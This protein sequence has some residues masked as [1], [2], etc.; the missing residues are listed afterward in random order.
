MDIKLEDL[1]REIH[2]ALSHYHKGIAD[3]NTLLGN[4]LLVQQQQQKLQ[5]QNVPTR[6]RLATNAVLLSGVENLEQQFPKEAEILR[7]RFFDVL[8]IEKA[9]KKVGYSPDHANRLQREGIKHLAEIL[10]AQEEMARNEALKSLTAYLPRDNDGVKLFGVDELRGRLL[11]VLLRPEQ[12]WIVAITGI[13]GIGKT[14]LAESLAFEVAKRF[15]FKHI[16]YHRVQD[17]HLGSDMANPAGVYDSFLFDMSRQLWPEI[18]D[19][20]ILANENKVLQGLKENPNLIII[21]NLELEGDIDYLLEKASY[22]VNPS[23]LLLTSRFQ[24]YQNRSI[25]SETVNALSEPDSLALM[26]HQAEVANIATVKQA[27]DE[28]LKSIFERTGGNPQALKL[29][30]AL[31]GRLPLKIVLQN[32][33]QASPGRIEEMY[34]DIYWQSWRSLTPEAQTLLQAM[35]LVSE[36]DGGTMEQLLETTALEETQFW[37][38]VALLHQR[39]LLLVHGSLD[40][41]SYTIHQLTNTFLA[42]EINKF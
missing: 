34:R 42:T 24:P 6:L 28:Q 14:S 3:P 41:R 31:L 38:A 16:F 27:S 23:R 39:S 32:L 8:S 36:S 7:Y 19:R 29:M 20:A 25:H 21:D 26:R 2:V 22:F 15:H 5:T 35:A 13:G 17:N 11:A 40:N 9:S 10:L 1:T 12:P 33:R 4:F 37:E 18:T 30:I